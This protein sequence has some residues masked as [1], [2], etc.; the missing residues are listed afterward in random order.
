MFD[1]VMIICV[2]VDWLGANDKDCYMLFNYT[3]IYEYICMYVYIHI[4]IHIYIYMCV[5]IDIYIYV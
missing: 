4:H 3:N 5:C 2:N 1:L